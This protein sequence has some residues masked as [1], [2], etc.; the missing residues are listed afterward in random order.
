MALT[1]WDSLPM[2]LRI[3]IFDF[4]RSMH[5]AER[6]QRLISLQVKRTDILGVEALIP[7]ALPKFIPD[8]YHTVCIVVKRKNGTPYCPA[9]VTTWYEDTELRYDW[10]D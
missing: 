10:A 4:K 7:E 2:E 6:Q 3:M 5:F 1:S 9:Y 8:R